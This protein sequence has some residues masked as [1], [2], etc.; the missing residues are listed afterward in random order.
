MG[1]ASGVTILQFRGSWFCREERI[2]HRA[3]TAESWM[4]AALCLAP[5][6]RHLQ[7]LAVMGQDS[8]NG[9]SS[10]RPFFLGGHKQPA[11]RLHQQGLRVIPSTVLFILELAR[12][13]LLQVWGMESTSGLWR[14]G[15]SAAL[16]SPGHWWGVKGYERGCQRNMREDAANKHF[17]SNLTRV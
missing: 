1:E 17:P 16:C 4:G 5:R 9:A 15:Y 2:G 8:E 6:F 13:R 11:S 3:R 12:D 7:G 10:S 14:P